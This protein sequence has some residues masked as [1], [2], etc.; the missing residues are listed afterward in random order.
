MVS[1]DPRISNYKQEQLVPLFREIE[2]QLRLIPGVQRVGSVAAAP[3]TSWVWE[4]DVQVEGKLESGP[5]V[6]GSSGWTRVTP[7]FFETLGDRMVMGRP[8]T[9]EDTASTRPVA[10]V[11]EAFA[12]K[13]FG[14]ENP[15]GQHFGPASGKNAGMYEIVGVA[16]D[17]DFGNGVQPM[18]FLP[19]AQSTNLLDA[20]AEEREVQSHY[21][22]NVLISAQADPAELMTQVK[23]TLANTAPNLVVNSIQ[24][25]SEVVHA[26]FA[27]QRMIAS[28]TWLF[29]AV[30][31]AL[32][33]VGLYGVTA[34]GVE[35]R[36][37][38]IGVRMALGAG[39]GSVVLM[40]LREAFGQVGIGLALG[41]PAAIGAGY[42]MAS[43]LFGVKP[44][45][46]LLLAGATML[47][48]FAA[49]CAAV[50]P[51]RRAAAIDPMR[52]IRSE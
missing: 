19:E 10:V 48:G 21:L 17:V 4:H 29:G 6:D 22:G 8:I 14:R 16:S 33:A 40:V 1:I 31:L 42:L 41:I 38:E 20:E 9:D 5:Q 51:A 44:Y 47:L 45:N 12:K 49:L 30:G 2:G 23:K 43:Q 39:R 11:N 15:S 13:F 35:Q 32:A 52:A 7:D 50:I 37:N 27:Q 18:Y 36:A 26:N 25:Y 34:Y 46:P 28:L 3:L 24:P